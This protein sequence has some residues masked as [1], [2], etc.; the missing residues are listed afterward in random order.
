MTIW[1][2]WLVFPVVLGLLSLGCGLLAERAAGVAVAASLRLPLGF[3]AVVVVS[4]LA[5]L[6]GRT[7][8]LAAPAVVALAVLGIGLSL[9]W[10]RPRGGW[11]L[12]AAVG[13]FCVFAA[14]F[15]LSGHVTFGGYI[16]LDDTAT[17]LAML[18]RAMQHG[19]DTAGLPPSTYEAT[20]STS[21]AY[22]YPLGSLLPLGVGRVLVAQD[23]AW[24]WQPY[25]TF[26][27]A[28]LAC[29]LY[30]LSAGLVVSPRLRALVAF[31]G[32]QA[33]L[34]YGYAL[35]GGVKELA[36]AAVVVLVVALVPVTVEAR[37]IRAVV[38]L[39]LG[40]AAVLAVS[41]LGGA[42]WLVVPVG[43]L[44]L[45]RWRV[46][47]VPDTVRTALALG[48]ATALFSLPTIWIAFRWLGRSGAF[49][50]SGE[51]GNLFGRL[52]VLQVFGIWPSGDFRVAPH[53]LDA[54]R[55]LA[56]LAGVAALFALV[57]AI[58][59][60]V[61]ELPVAVATAAFACVVYVGL[62]SPWIGAKALASASPIV[63]AAAFTGAAVVFEGGRRVEAVAAGSVLLV[64]LLWSNV[65]Q[66]R[67]VDL[68]PGARLAELQTIGEKFS[69]DGPTLLAEYEPYGARHFLRNM[70][71][72][73]PSELRRRPI[74]LRA[75][76]TAPTGA[77]PDL[78]ELTLSSVLA[79]RTIVL[80]R[81]GVA[82][83]P[84]SV[85]VPV[86]TGRYYQVWQRPA[87]TGSIA[88]HLSLGSR[89]Q[90]AAVPSCGSVL[91]VAR[92]AA[93]DG[94]E[95]AAVKRPPAIVIGTDG[96]VGLPTSFAAYGEPT[97]VLY[98]REPYTVTSSFDAP[99]GANYGVWVGGSYR[100]GVSV[101]VDGRRVGTVR[102][103]LGWPGTF[104]YLGAI[105]LA[106]GRHTLRFR[107]DGPGLRPGSG[108]TPP[109]GVG[110]VVLSAGTPDSPITYVRPSAAR[111]LCGQSLDWVEALR[112]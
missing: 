62:G 9:P 41:S 16:K 65:L 79:Y 74:Y 49:T 3:A 54:T 58:R 104:T 92:V 51:L 60:R 2:A 24:L 35:W 52:S 112:G 80:R 40:A 20:L 48:A 37:T 71:A 89:L 83:R 7:A 61:V 15:V 46:R 32:G 82:S 85:Y 43:A 84:P 27:A 108:G 78:D 99:A 87:Y 19:Y 21:L 42:A 55:V 28:L 86:W 67:D 106:P 97:D 103:S 110:P 101:E 33:A 72:E 53:D 105:R 18:D 6:G 94:G 107:Y 95:V 13:V 50:S 102:D 4:E 70:A 31:A 23:A 66:Y 98:L 12:A 76:G 8:P 1:I 5:I 39:A 26:L 63:L 22:G 73:A 38:P 64:A 75:G 56:A 25:L 88:E 34:L 69:G 91:A 14:P 93:A 47:G 10:R 59:R 100:S 17:Y 81:S 30:R 57:V 77:S 29:G 44:L 11:W 45:L 111:T 36:T 109:F 96:T 68:A 90:P